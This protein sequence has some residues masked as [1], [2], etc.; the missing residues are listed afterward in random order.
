MN[1]LLPS[2]QG[3]DADQAEGDALPN[4]N[5]RVQSDAGKGKQG[6]GVPIF[7]NVDA[8]QSLFKDSCRELVDLRQKVFRY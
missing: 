7:P 5:L 6:S 4:G 3:A 8:L 1:E 2:F